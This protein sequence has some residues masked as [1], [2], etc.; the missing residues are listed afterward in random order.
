MIGM[1][2]PFAVDVAPPGWLLCDGSIVS[3]ADYPELAERIH[4]D[5]LSGTDIILPDMTGRVALGADGTTLNYGDTGGEMEH[6]LTVGEL[7]AHDHTYLQP[8]EVDL[9]LAGVPTPTAGLIQPAQTGPEGNG[10]PHNN[11]PPY[12][13]LSWYVFSGRN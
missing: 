4:P 12:L 8:V 11:M 5:N 3:Q 9:N 7:P 10:E 2:A 1:L 6:T 13:V